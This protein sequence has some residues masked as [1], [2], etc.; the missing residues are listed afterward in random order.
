MKDD[1]PDRS[2]PTV[3]GDSHAD[4]IRILEV[5]NRLLTDQMAEL[6]LEVRDLRRQGDS[7][8]GS[9]EAELASNSETTAEVRDILQ[10]AKAG[11][12]VI[13]GLGT[14]VKWVGGIATGLAAAWGLYVTARGGIPK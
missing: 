1:H 8:F 6:L 4:R 11:L 14:F 12:R 3:P 13:G 10:V 7:R 9:L 5:S 2:I